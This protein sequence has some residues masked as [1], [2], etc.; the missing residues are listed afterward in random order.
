ME[1]KLKLKSEIAL[2]SYDHDVFLNHKIVDSD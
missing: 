2:K 1:P